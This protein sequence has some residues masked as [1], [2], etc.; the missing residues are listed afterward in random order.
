MEARIK[1]L[2]KSKIS[3]H[4]LDLQRETSCDWVAQQRPDLYARSLQPRDN[5]AADGASTSNNEYVIHLADLTSQGSIE[6]KKE[7]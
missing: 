2:G 4:H 7:K 6:E 3:A 5:S 1:G